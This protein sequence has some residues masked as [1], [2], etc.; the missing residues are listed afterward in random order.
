MDTKE[1]IVRQA[2]SADTKFIEH[3][4]QATFDHIDNL[5]ATK[6]E[7]YSSNVNRF[8][9][10]LV[11][12]RMED[13][14]P[15]E[16][17]WGMMIKHY[18]SLRKFVFE[19]V[20]PKRRSPAKWDEKIDDMITYL[21]LLKAMIRRRTQIEQVIDARRDSKL[22]LVDTDPDSVLNRLVDNNEREA[23]ATPEK[24]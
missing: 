22:Q 6:G 10:F 17:L 12:S 3:T 24:S 18:V 7:E 21:I 8:E 2:L 4:K 11:T 19:L 13:E 23:K 9:N 1:F 15:E 16:S 14:T 5:L 20:T